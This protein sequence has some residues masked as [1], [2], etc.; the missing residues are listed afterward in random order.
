MQT[1]STLKN[2]KKCKMT[3]DITKKKKVLQYQATA[4]NLIKMQTLNPSLH[5]V[6]AHDKEIMASSEQSSEATLQNT[7]LASKLQVLTQR[8]PPAFT[9]DRIQ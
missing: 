6:C 8:E 2:K 9:I 3:N 4:L 1:K 5:T 7:V